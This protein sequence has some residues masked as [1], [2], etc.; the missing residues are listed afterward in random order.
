MPNKHFYATDTRMS[1]NNVTGSHIILMAAIAWSQL[2][3]DRGLTAWACTYKR[4]DKLKT[5][6]VPSTALGIDMG[7]KGNGSPYSI[8]ERR[9][10][11]LIK[12][13]GS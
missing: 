10:P 1:T 6:P 4:V 8:A 5:S 13:L 12:V 2:P 9:V 7:I 11:E 3:V